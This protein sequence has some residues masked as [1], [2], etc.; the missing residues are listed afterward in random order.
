M[1]NLLY[2]P[3]YYYYYYYRAQFAINIHENSIQNLKML[4]WILNIQ[5]G[6]GVDWNRLAEDRDQWRAILNA[7][8][9]LRVPCS[10]GLRNCWLLR[11]DSDL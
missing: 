10:A 11:R 5:A 8:M 9:D 6:K 3:N 4:K 7:V 2:V 1:I